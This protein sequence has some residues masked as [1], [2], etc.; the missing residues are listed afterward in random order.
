MTAMTAFV[1]IPYTESFRDS[2]AL[3]IKPALRECGLEAILAE[4]E[5]TP[6][7]I[8]VQLIQAIKQAR[9]CIADLTE[10]NPNVM[11]EVAIAHS[12]EKPVILLTRGDPARIPFDIRHH[13]AIQYQADV[14]GHERLST[15]LQGAI[16]S[17]LKSEEST[18]DLLRKVLVPATAEVER[19]SFVVAASPLSY[20]SAFR[21]RG[22]WKERDLIT[23]SDHVG[24]RGLMQ[25]FGL[26]YGLERLPELLNPDDFDDSVLDKPNMRMNIY[27]IGSP[28]AN[29]WTGILMDRFFEDREPGW[30]FKPD[31]E[32]KEIM[33]PRVILR[34]NRVPYLPNVVP[35]PHI[36]KWDF[37]LVI[38]GPHPM[39]S[40]C[41][42]MGLAGR[43]SLGTEATCLAV[44]NPDCLRRLSER[45]QFE[46]IDLDDH[47]QAFCAIVSVRSSQLKTDKSSFQVLDVIRYD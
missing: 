40:A 25:A 27:S 44:T 24:V 1:M 12:S 10:A 13:R 16:R 46:R 6:G 18:A 31:P 30:E 28:K 47:R 42:F 41:M 32:S 9:L 17:T 43:G 38:R 4:S 20:R 5:L 35:D 36:L 15:L 21:A 37:G 8:D 22:G 39:D 26:I 45:L 19:A 33:N 14:P 3:A 7:P 34:R 29:R 11:Y 2:Y 23:F